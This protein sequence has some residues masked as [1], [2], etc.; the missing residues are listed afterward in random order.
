M[1]KSG[2]GTAGQKRSADEFDELSAKDLRIT[3]NILNAKLAE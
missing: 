2:S 3:K 1:R